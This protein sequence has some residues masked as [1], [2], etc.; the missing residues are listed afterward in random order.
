MELPDPIFISVDSNTIVKE[1]TEYYESLTS[2]KLQPGQAETLLIN[3]FAYRE[4]LLR[5]GMNEAGKQNLLAFARYP[6]LDYIAELVGVK[7]SPAAP[8]RCQI[9]LT[10][11]S[12][13]GGIVLPN[14]LK[15]QSIDGKAI[16]MISESKNVAPN[17]TVIDVPAVCTMDGIIGN[18]Y[19][20]GEISIILDPQP[21]LTAASNLTV[22]N[23]GTDEETDEKLRERTRI[24]PSQFSVAG[25]EDAYRFFALSAHP[26]IIDVAI[27]SPIPGQVNIYPLLAN[28][29]EPSAEIIDAVYAACNAEKRRPLN[30]TVVVLAPLKRDYTITVNLTLLNSAIDS[31]IIQ[32]VTT[33]LHTYVQ[34]R[35]ISLGLDIVVTQII[36]RCMVAGVYTVHVAS[37]SADIVIPDDGYGNCI[38]I[39][40]NV[41]GSSNE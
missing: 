20:V 19:Q 40:V 18:G 38:G 9:R 36:A 12:G 4:Q 41:T 21:Y 27:T 6:A 3:A 13:H 39:I 1:M 10:L 37:P 31:Q 17:V 25:A 29:Q 16:F 14:D 32:L 5:I 26:S 24:A 23:A 2:R 15:V 33:N 11:I 7:R 34:E 22:T 8:A 35:Y 28:G 30:D